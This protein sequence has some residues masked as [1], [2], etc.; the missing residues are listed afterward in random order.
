[1][2]PLFSVPPASCPLT[3]CASFLLAREIDPSLTFVCGHSFPALAEGSMSF[4][5][6]VALFDVSYRVRQNVFYIY[7]LHSGLL[8]VIQSHCE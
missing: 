1:M 2:T 5:H 6:L 3:K 7:F 4:L 8:F